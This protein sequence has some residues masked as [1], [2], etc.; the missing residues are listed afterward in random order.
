MINNMNNEYFHDL[1]ILRLV[2]TDE[3]QCRILRVQLHF[4]RVWMVDALLEMIS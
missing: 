2:G 4:L 3:L 1:L